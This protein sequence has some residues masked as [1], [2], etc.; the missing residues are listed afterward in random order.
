MRYIN[1][2]FTYLLTY[3]LTSCFVHLDL[4]CDNLIT[5]GFPC[6][7]TWN[8]FFQSRVFQSCI[9][10]TC[11]V[12]RPR[13]ETQPAVQ[14]R[15]DTRHVNSATQ[16]LGGEKNDMSSFSSVTLA[17][18][19]DIRS[20]D[21]GQ[22]WRGLKTQDEVAGFS[23]PNPIEDAGFSKPRPSLRS[24][25]DPCQRLQGPQHPGQGWFSLDS[26]LNEY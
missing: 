21:P 18:S 24:S 1:P 7:S 4:L 16:E 19:Q 9:F 3:L 11:T 5:A 26:R 10:Q 14:L 17:W 2:R 22:G 15:H 8:S 23:R 6:S 12:N 25:Q 13:S 20:R